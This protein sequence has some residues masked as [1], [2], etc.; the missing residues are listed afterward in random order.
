MCWSGGCF[1]LLQDITLLKEVF[2]WDQ[3]KYFLF[4]LTI[5]KFG[6]DLAS[7]NWNWKVFNW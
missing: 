4:K 1:Y 7:S 3:A 5:L 2:A 6:Q